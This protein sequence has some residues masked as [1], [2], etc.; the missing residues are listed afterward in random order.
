MRMAVGGL[1][2][3]FALYNW[4]RPDSTV[5][6]RVLPLPLTVTTCE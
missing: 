5:A 2:I 3:A 6:A 4:F 1:L